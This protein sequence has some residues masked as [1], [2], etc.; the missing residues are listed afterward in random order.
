M[1]NTQGPAA[2]T[3]PSVQKVRDRIVPDWSA[4][5][6][7]ARLHRCRR[8]LYLHDCATEGDNDRIGERIHKRMNGL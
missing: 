7:E 6:L 4:E 5:P 3:T 2:S 1:N 8:M